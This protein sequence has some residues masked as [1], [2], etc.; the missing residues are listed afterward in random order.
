MDS[1]STS[2]CLNCWLINDLKTVKTSAFKG[3][4]SDLLISYLSA[5]Y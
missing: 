5:I 3:D 1:N 2:A 4:M